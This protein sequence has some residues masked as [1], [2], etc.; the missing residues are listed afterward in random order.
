MKR[1]SK[2][3]I[4]RELS[5]FS[6]DKFTKDGINY[7]CKACIKA[8]RDTNMIIL[9]GL[10]PLVLGVDFALLLCVLFNGK[11]KKSSL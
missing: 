11:S 7:R 5:C 10:L 9:F 1:C 8:Y 6:K 3:K 4:K 2:C